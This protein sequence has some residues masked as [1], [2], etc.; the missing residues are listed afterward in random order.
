MEEDDIVAISKM[1]IKIP[2]YLENAI[3]KGL[4]VRAEDRFQSA[5]AFLAAIEVSEWVMPVEPVQPF[6]S[7]Y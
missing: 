6:P 1:G 7:F 4:E 3:M 2:A 5:D